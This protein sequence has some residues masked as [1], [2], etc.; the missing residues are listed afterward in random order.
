MASDYARI[1]EENEKRYGTDI[2]RIGPMLLSERYADR[3][4]FIFEL[5]QNAEDALARRAG[6]CGSR[7]VK[8]HLANGVLRVSHYGKPFDEDDVRAI[9]GIALSTKGLN[10]IGRFG[11]GFKSVYAFSDRPEIHSGAEDFAI[12]SYVSPVTTPPIE[13]DAD[14]TVILLP[15]RDAADREIIVSALQRLGPSVL[16]SLREI[17][18][19]EWSVEGGPYGLYLRGRSDSDSKE[20]GVRRII[21]IGEENGECETEQTWIIFSRPVTTDQGGTAGHVEI[22]FMV[23]RERD[24][25]YETVVPVHSSPLVVFFP[26]VLE[27]HLGFLVQGPYRTTPSRDNVPRSDVWNQH[28]VRETATLLIDALRWLRD[29][30]VLNTAA[31]QCLPLDLTRFGKESMFAPL[32]EAT[33]QALTT[34][35]LLP[36]FDG[37]YVQGSK[38]R[39]ARTQELRELFTPDQ[40][41]ALFGHEDELVWLSSDITQDRTPGLRQYLLQELQIAEVTPEAVITRLNKAFLE[42]QSDSWITRLYE[43]LGGQPALLRRLQGL[44]LVRLEDGTHVAPKANDRPQ[45]FLPGKSTTG[46]PTV[47]STVCSTEAAR[48]FLKSLGLTEPDPVDDVISNNRQ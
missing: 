43:F 38:A 42:A 5:L 9:C 17:E 13:R 15:L 19:I 12:E 40:L 27:T 22:A 1:R 36:R 29:H 23:D 26:T 30:N 25:K 37:G 39:L 4:H 41:A 2:G 10:A 48:E 7:A 28:L 14:E 33:K 32:F 3:T 31:L 46:F 47:R 20:E 45:A 11:I 8:F 18:G 24:G 6:S 34:E 44:P 21:I 16:L 35:P